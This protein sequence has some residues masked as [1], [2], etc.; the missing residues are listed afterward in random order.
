MPKTKDL[1]KT[2]EGIK[3]DVGD[4]RLLSHEEADLAE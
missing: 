1:S 2:I 4:L 3:S